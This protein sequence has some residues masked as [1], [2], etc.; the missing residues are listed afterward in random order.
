MERLF[1]NTKHFTM[2]QLF[3]LVFLLLGFASSL[4]A[5]EACVADTTFQDSLGVFPLPFDEEAS[6][7]AGITEAACIN[8][9]Y[10][11]VFTIAVGDSIDFGTSRLPIDSIILNPDTAI[12]N[13]PA[14]IDYVCNPPDCI[15]RKDQLGCIALTG[16]AEASNA[17][18]EYNLAITG[19]VFSGPLPF[20]LTF[21]DEAIAP[22]EYI[23]T[24]NEEDSPDCAVVNTEN[25]LSEKVRMQLQP[26]PVRGFAQILISVPTTQRYQFQIFDVLGKLVQERNV[27][28]FKGE[29]RLD[30]DA[31]NLSNGVYFYALNNGRT[32]AA[33]RMI[34]SK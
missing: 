31:S 30:F 4:W 19:N 33:K 22:G 20:E 21:P 26:N 25:V 28:L 9:P 14:G 16:T 11:F 10:E 2:K 12:A 3:T 17:S 7:D 8:K 5:Q 29:N 13:L 24:L 1:R 32:L 27:Q 34:V 6:P 15:F 18:G 23:L